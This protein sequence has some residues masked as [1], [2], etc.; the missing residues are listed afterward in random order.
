MLRTLTRTA[1]IGAAALLVLACTACGPLSGPPATTA[2][3]Q[4]QQV[5]DIVLKADASASN[6]Q[7]SNSVSGLSQGWSIEIDHEG[8][9]TPEL[10]ESILVPVAALD[11]NPADISLY[12]FEPGT[13]DAIDIGPAADELGIPWSPVGSGGTWLSGQ[14]G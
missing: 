14:V 4:Q 2:Q 1:Q 7:A 13:D 10:L 9:I 6:V 8:E 12:F 11:S 5:V 3:D